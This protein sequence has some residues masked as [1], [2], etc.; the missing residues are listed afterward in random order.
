MNSNCPSFRIILLQAAEIYRAQYIVNEDLVVKNTKDSFDKHYRDVLAFNLDLLY[1]LE[2]EDKFDIQNNTLKSKTINGEYYTDAFVNVSFEYSLWM[3]DKYERVFDK[4]EIVG[5]TYTPS[6]MREAIYRDGF[7]LNGKKYVRYKR[8][9]SAAKGGSCLFIKESLYRLMDSW[10]KA[11]LNEKKDNCLNNLT[12]YEAYKALSLSSLI[13]T[14]ELN[15]YNI[16]FVKDFKH[17]LKDE[18]VIK[19]NYI[20]GQGLVAVRGKNDIENNIFDGE[21]LMDDSIF[22]E[23]GYSGDNLKGMML[24]RNR[25]FKACAFNT[26][27]QDWFK[28]NNIT[29]VD[30]LNGI[31]FATD[32]KDI[33]LVVSESCLK[34]LKMTK[35]GF[36]KENIKRWCDAVSNNRLSTFG[37]VKTD[38][39]TRFFNGEM[40]ETTYQLLNT[41]SLK[42]DTELR[43]LLSPYFDYVNKIRDIK[44]TPE[45]VKLFLKGEVKEQDI[46]VTNDEDMED[47]SEDTPIEDN[48]LN[49]SSYSFKNK[50]CY[51]MLD[52]CKDFKKTNLFKNHLFNNVIDS[53]HLKLYDGRIL[54][55][56]T[57][58]TLFGN[59]LEYLQY[60]IKK[61]DKSLLEANGVVSSLNRDEIYC[62]FFN[63]EEIAGSRAP[64]M[65]MGNLLYAHNKKPKDLDKWFNLTRN[66]AVVDAINNNIQQRLNG[67]DYDS[68]TLLLTN[69][70]VIV[71]ATKK[72]YHKFPVPCTGFD[73]KSIG[74]NTSKDL[75][76]NIIDLDNKI[77]NNRVGMIVNL[78]QKLNSHYWNKTDKYDNPNKGF[79]DVELYNKI[80]ILAVLAGAEIDSAKKSFDF[81]TVSVFNKVNK[82]AIDNGFDEEPVFFYYV[83][84][85][86]K[87]KPTAGKIN[88]HLK[89]HIEKNRPFFNTT[90]DRLWKYTYENKESME[91]VE[92]IPFFSLVRKDI[93]TNGLSSSNYGQI[94]KTLDAL[95]RLKKVLYKKN[96][97]KKSSKTFEM[98]KREFND[99]IEKCYQEIKS[100][101]S[102]VEKTRKLIKAIEELKN[103]TPYTLLF[104]LL[105]IISVKEKELGYTYKDLFEIDGGIPSLERTDKRY[106]SFDLFDKYY[107]KHSS[108]DTLYS[109]L[110]SLLKE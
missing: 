39:E 97:A 15:P 76:G 36:N 18:E 63:D 93:T 11:G 96:K 5:Q 80:A 19:V 100:G 52:L 22:H 8:T 34:Y 51:E 53:F 44:N 98:E 48:E 81:T 106:A 86:T 49:Y 87:D 61:D 42:K 62:S 38:K 57:Y 60:I 104:V 7:I 29:S 58:A 20:E 35:G 72:N 68:D 2:Y 10:S 90:M 1:L 59:P 21:G 92:T 31:T 71:N 6:Q 64:H 66:I 105:Y 50:V 84:P 94:N 70:R 77:A 56:G 40:V 79:D 12:S 32:I 23:C 27:L 45:Y 4:K 75:I 33:V 43:P 107:Y 88:S 3:N 110:Q 67:A 26:R 83:A 103:E 13:K 82:Y 16:L 109:G 17:V 47:D 25:F 108:A 102:K 73:S 28:Y 30:Q 91:N 78:S 95:K 99:K 69:N 14:F 101:I 54:I 89:E 41:L 46:E 24:L 9:A 85:E 65:T 37:V 74:L 55:E